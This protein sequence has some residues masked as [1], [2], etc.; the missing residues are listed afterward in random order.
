MLARGRA[1]P[2]RMSAPAPDMMRS[3]TFM[4]FSGCVR[5]SSEKS[6]TLAPRRPGVVGLY[7]R[8]GIGLRPL[9]FEDLDGVAAGQG[10]QRPLLI[11]A[12]PARVSRPLHLPLPGDG[13]DRG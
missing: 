4:P 5:E 8:T 9:R 3:P 7:L 13:V 1:F 10:D 2:G 11:G 12:A 6:E